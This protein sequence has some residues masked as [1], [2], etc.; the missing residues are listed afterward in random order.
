MEAN[1]ILTANILDLLFEG[2]NKEYGAYD[3]RKTYNWRI[4]SSLCV[5]L[6]AIIIFIVAVSG[7]IRNDSER[8]NPPVI[9]FNPTNPE[10]EKKE[11]IIPPKLPKAKPIKTLAYVPSIIVRDN[12]VK[13]PPIKIDELVDARIDTKTI[14]GENDKGI[15]APPQ[16][17]KNSQ[18]MESLEKALKDDGLPFIKV[19]VEAEFKGNWNAYVKKEI[20]KNIDELTEAGE[21]GTCMVKFIVSKDGSVSNVEAITMKGSKLA[22][23]AVNA[24][25][26][27]P[28]WIPAQ[29][30]GQEVNAYRHQPITFKISEY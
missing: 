8:N 18:V 9:V 7:K 28:K 30:N 17:I 24:I 27:G 23:V 22:E 13:E 4:G 10:P 1:K 21:S 14:E 2:R 3:I 19:E 11:V 26:R 20:E 12:Q 29:Q 5:T 15:V 6:I 25:R 16:K